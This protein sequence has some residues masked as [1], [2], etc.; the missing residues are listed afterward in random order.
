MKFDMCGKRF[1]A[2]T[3]KAVAELALPINVV[4][5]I[6]STENMPGGS[7]VKPGD[8]VTSLSGQT[9]EIINTDA[10]GRLILSDAL[11]YAERFDPLA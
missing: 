7:A 2:G 1:G 8:V 9:I 3:L 6:P 4:G 5:L 11:S 10:E